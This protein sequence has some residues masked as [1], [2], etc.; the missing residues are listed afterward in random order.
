MNQLL[1]RTLQSH[2]AVPTEIWE[3]RNSGIPAPLLQP[4]PKFHIWEDFHI[5]PLSKD[6]FFFPL[7]GWHLP[8]FWDAPP[9]QFPGLRFPLPPLSAQLLW[10]FPYFK[11]FF[12]LYFPFFSPFKFFQFFSFFPPPLKF[13]SPFFPPFYFVF[14]SSF[15]PL[16]FHYFISYLFPFP[17]SV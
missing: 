1:P 5:F 15:F 13:F 17:F 2:V 6:F 16:S 9:S 10:F 7:P 11:F 8:K 14:F 3:F 12:P 4:H